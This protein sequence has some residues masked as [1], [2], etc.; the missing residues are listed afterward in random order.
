MQREIQVPFTIAEDHADGGWVAAAAMTPESF[1][2]GE[3]ETREEAIEDFKAALI[4]LVDEVGIP[5]QLVVTLD[6]D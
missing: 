3:G 5:E 1:A 4:A 6:V 2:N